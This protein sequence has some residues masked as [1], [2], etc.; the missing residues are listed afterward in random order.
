VIEFELAELSI[1][2]TSLHA[3]HRRSETVAETRRL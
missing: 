1:T 2:A 3:D